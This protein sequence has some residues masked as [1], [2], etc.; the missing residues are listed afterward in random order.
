MV[1]QDEVIFFLQKYIDNF[2]YFSIKTDVV[3]TY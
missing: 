3:D 1:S 2:F